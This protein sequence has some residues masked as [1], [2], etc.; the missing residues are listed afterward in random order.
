MQGSL[1]DQLLSAGF[2]EKKAA[3]KKRTAKPVKSSSSNRPKR[4]PDSG[5]KS[6]RKSP[7]TKNSNKP[8]VQE[9]VVPYTPIKSNASAGGAKKSGSGTATSAV[10]LANKRAKQRVRE[11]VRVNQVRAGQVDSTVSDELRAL[12]K[13]HEVTN[14]QG[15]SKFH[16]QIGNKITYVYVKPDVQVKLEQGMLII[17]QLDAQYCLVESQIADQL[18]ETIPHL[19]VFRNT[20]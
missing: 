3:E 13:K 4:K 18:I 8:F 20:E 7:A 1:K 9:S 12:I 17:V 19:V 5:A 6:Q 15:T 16:F 14:D 10:K 2:S 11:Q